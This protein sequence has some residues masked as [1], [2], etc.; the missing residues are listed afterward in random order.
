MHKDQSARRK[1]IESDTIVASKQAKVIVRTLFWT[2]RKI[3]DEL[4]KRMETKHLSNGTLETDCYKDQ[5]SFD[6]LQA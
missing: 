1:T 3:F 6:H 4:E 2:M 5:R